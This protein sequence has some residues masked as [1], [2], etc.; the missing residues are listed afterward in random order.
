MLEFFP[1]VCEAVSSRPKRWEETCV[2]LADPLSLTYHL[3]PVLLYCHFIISSRFLFFK[4]FHTTISLSG[5]Y[6]PYS[7]HFSLHLIHVPYTL[8]SI[9]RLSR[10]HS[11]SSIHIP[12]LQPTFSPWHSHQL[13]G[14][15]TFPRCHLHAHLHKRL[16]TS[17]LASTLN[18]SLQLHPR[19]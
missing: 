4:I 16:S 1:Q 17:T 19:L 15:Y 3:P 12:S 7:I 5:A 6:L 9:L 11:P 2:S 13:P 18:S 10:P 14:I 8:A